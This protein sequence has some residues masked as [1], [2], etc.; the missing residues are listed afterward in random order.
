MAGDALSGDVTLA[1]DANTEAELAGYMLYYGTASRTYGPG[2]NVNNVTTYTVTGLA[3]G[4]YY[5]A[6]TAYSIYG[7]ETGYSNEVSA[8]IAQSD[9]SAP[10]VTITSPA[11]GAT[12]SSATSALSLGGTASDSIGVTQVTWSNDRGGSG[13]ASGTTSWSV[14]SIA[15]QT[16]SNVITVTARDAAGNTSTD[17]LTVTYTPPDTTPPTVSGVA[18]S[19]ITASSAAISWTTSEP[20]DSQVDYG[21]TTA[22]GSS[23]TL[24][25][26]MVVSHSQA[27]AGLAPGT[28]YHY[29]VKSKDA[30][31]N[32]ATSGDFTFTTQLG[33]SYSINP[34][35]QA[36]TALASTGSVAVAA[37]DSCTWTASSDAAWIR[38]MSGAAGQGN[39]TVSY[40]V[41]AN[42]TQSARAGILTIAGQSLAV[43][44][45]KSGCDIT[46]DGAAN[47]VDLQRL[48]NVILGTG[49][50]PGSCDVNADG[51]VDVVDLQ[52][53]INVILGVSSCPNE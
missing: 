13:T 15:L 43:A 28:L 3:P 5:F 32:L 10:T 18:S 19:A 21:T 24:S 47:I 23:T 14:A 30:D 6:V 31:G 45:A 34:A 39:G 20:S 17:T 7:Y 22:Y 41:E 35:S 53:L 1:W 46:G 42:T 8:T 51:R 25:T 48:V 27:L 2:I 29:R 44:Q 12:Y 37:P 11:S 33:C 4:T 16:G 9:T 49:T 36:F 26:G 38:I 40:S 52:A 50:C